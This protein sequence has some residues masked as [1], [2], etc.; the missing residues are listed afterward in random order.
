[1]SELSSPF[2]K[3]MPGIPIREGAPPVSRPTPEEI[4]AFPAE[5]RA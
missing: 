2:A 1:M 5:A 3:P 4:E